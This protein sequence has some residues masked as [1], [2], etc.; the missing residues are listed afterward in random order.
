LP[1]F[2]GQPVAKPY[3]Q[4][5]HALDSPYSHCQVRD[6]QPAV[7]CLVRKTAHRPETKVDLPGAR[8][9]DSRCISVPEDHGLAE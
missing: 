2:G 8:W 6:E 5:L 4:L 7:C 9:R 1:L 3:T